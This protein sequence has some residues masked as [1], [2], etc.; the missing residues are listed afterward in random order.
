M[1]EQK[2]M[3]VPENDEPQSE[4]EH[5]EEAAEP[6][7]SSVPDIYDSIPDTLPEGYVFPLADDY[8][9]EEWEDDEEPLEAERE[10]PLK[11]AMAIRAAAAALLI[12]ISLGASFL[13]GAAVTAFYEKSISVSTAF[14]KKTYT[15]D[16]CVEY[17]IAPSLFGDRLTVTLRMSDGERVKLLSSSTVEGEGLE[18]EHG[19]LY[20][21]VLSVCEELKNKG[22][23]RT[24]RERKTIESELAE[25]EDIGETVR[26]LIE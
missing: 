2:A 21:Y 6:Q 19:S 20:A 9:E 1:S 24:V 14:G 17:E 22:V 10:E 13:S 15:L 18:K 12:A 5:E 16:E 7:K 23:E 3:Y 8:D 25:R 11:V 4:P 26:K